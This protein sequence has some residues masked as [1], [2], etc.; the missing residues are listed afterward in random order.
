MAA[1]AA[2]IAMAAAAAAAGR[3]AM[4][5][6]NECAHTSTRATRDAFLCEVRGP[7]R[8]DESN[9]R[10]DTDGRTRVYS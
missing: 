10:E 3:A 8:V 5:Q 7:A 4:M 2:A 9:W 1:A 6:V